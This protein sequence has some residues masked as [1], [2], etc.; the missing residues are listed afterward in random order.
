MLSG[1]SVLKPTI[2]PVIFEEDKLIEWLTALVFLFTGIIGL[3]RFWPSRR[4]DFF[5]L[6][7][8]LFGVLAF[9]D[10]LSFGERLFDLEF[11]RILG[12]KLDSVH[13]L[14]FIGKKVIKGMT[15][16]PYLFTAILAVGFA[17]I[18]YILSRFLI[19]RGWQMRLGGTSILII[20]ALAMVVLAQAIDVNLRIISSATLKPLYVEEILE[21]GAAVLML[22]FVMTHQLSDN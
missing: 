20:G 7:V 13:D 19:K 21:F 3:R 11:P 10:E 22:G 5:L 6:A 15:R 9:L 8:A 2:R 18:G 1:V 14:I 16:N 17:A 4:N 12:T